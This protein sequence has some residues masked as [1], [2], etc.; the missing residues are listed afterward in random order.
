MNPNYSMPKI[1]VVK[2][3]YIYIAV[4]QSDFG[5]VNLLCYAAPRLVIINNNENTNLILLIYTI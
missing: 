1:I 5:R 3:F 2:L 4:A